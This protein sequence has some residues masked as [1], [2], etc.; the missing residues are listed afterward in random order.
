MAMPTYGVLLTVAYDGTAFSGWAAQGPSSPERTVEST[1]EAAVKAID[2]RSSKMR[3]TSRTD[4]GVHAETQMVAFDAMQEVDARGWV[5][6]VNANL[7]D[8][9]AVRASRTV[10]LGYN[11]RHASLWKRYRYRLLLDSVRD[12]LERTRSWRVGHPLNLDRIAAAC[13]LLEG[14]HDFGAFRTARDA[15][16]TTV[17]T[18][19]RVAVETLSDRVVSIAVTGDAFMHNMVRIIV[20]TLVDIGR[21][22]FDEARIEQAFES[23]RRDDLGTTAPAHGL[24]L[25]HI[26]LA[27]PEGAGEPWPR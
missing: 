25:E 3:G 24:T 18:L 12:P 22:R 20:G 1:L 15:R 6:A 5:L 9:V 7:P 2:P 21:G 16:P 14:T 10:A 17:R 26:E 4:A 13:T 19:P 27:L 8:D 23:Q 11:P